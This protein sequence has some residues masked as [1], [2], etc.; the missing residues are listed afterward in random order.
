MEHS[1]FDVAARLYTAAGKEVL[2]PVQLQK[3][4]YYVFGWYGHLTYS[5]L[6]LEQMYAMRFGPVV[7]ELYRVHARQREVERAQIE[8]VCQEI[9]CDW[10]SEDHYLDAVID[11][12]WRHY[13]R[14]D[15]FT[16]ADISH[17]D[18]PWISA[19][20]KRGTRKRAQMS[21]EDVI[22][23]FAYEAVMPKELAVAL[24]DPTVSLIS[25]QDFRAMLDPASPVPELAPEIAAILAGDKLA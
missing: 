20:A 14:V 23:Y 3:L 4:A 5:P 10:S 12:V 9:G 8:D 24:P 2:A 1:V 19:W 17:K 11:A 15:Q 13:G 18:K 6:F 25:E 21:H 22:D 7:G 16:L